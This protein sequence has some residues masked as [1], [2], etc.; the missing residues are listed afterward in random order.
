MDWIWLAIAGALGTLSRYG[1]TGLVYRFWGQRLPLGTL[2]VNLIGSFLMPLVLTL[3][4][5]AGWFS[6]SVRLAI[7]IGFLGAFTTFST[8]AFE[9]LE[10]LLEGAWGSAVGY[11]LLN[12]VLGLTLA[13]LG[14]VVGRLIAGGVG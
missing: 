7:T 12:T 5:E 6:R 3:A 2:V 9:T 14:L 10:Y 8:F 11:F 4:L 13:W 1:L